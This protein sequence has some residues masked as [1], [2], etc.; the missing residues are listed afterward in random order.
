M[1]DSAATSHVAPSLCEL[2][3]NDTMNGDK[4]KDNVFQI[5]SAKRRNASDC[6]AIVR[7]R[8]LAGGSV[9]AAKAELK[10]PH[11]PT[12]GALINLIPHFVLQFVPLTGFDA[13]PAPA[14][15]VKPF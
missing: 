6:T 10:D 7:V 9:G 4:M 8:A 2:Y 11:Q 3:T 13:F 14:C 5:S 1:D 12:G 15:H